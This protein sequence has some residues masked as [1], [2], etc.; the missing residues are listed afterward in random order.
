[1]LRLSSF[2]MLMFI[3]AASALAADLPARKPGLWQLKLALEEF[4]TLP[5]QLAE[6][7]I[8]AAT[9]KL[10]NSSF[11]GGSGREDCSKKDVQVSG[12]TVTVDSVCKI[13]SMTV[14][15]HAV[16]TGDFN[17][18]YTVNVSSKR[19]GG[20]PGMAGSGSSNITIEAKWLGPC[21][22]DQK[23]GDMVM[24]GR[25]INIRDMQGAAGGAMRPG[26]PPQS[27]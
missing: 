27:K 20:P 2:A 6:H 7:C 5:P 25:T 18:A 23:P 21:K 8:D 1:M 16:V 12:S 9:D 24:M 26:M 22:A 10:M 11:G 17:S 14:T 19:E 13:S 4:A 3:P 15:T